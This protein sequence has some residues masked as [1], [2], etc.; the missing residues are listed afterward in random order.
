MD[1]QAALLEDYESIDPEDLGAAFLAGATDTPLEPEPRS[2]AELAGFQIFES[3]A[4]EP[5]A[6]DDEPDQWAPPRHG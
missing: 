1:P 4:E 6:G 5:G 3:E 2:T